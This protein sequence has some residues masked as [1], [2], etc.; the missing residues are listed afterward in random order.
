MSKYESCLIHLHSG[1][2]E[3]LLN[4]NWQNNK[5]EQWDEK[6]VGVQ[7]TYKLLLQFLDVDTHD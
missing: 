7:I 6:A 2:F 4:I 5:K 1:L 3:N